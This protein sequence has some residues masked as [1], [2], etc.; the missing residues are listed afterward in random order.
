MKWVVFVMKNA[1]L[2]K[3]TGK[4]LDAFMKRHNL[5]NADI[6]DLLGGPDAPMTE[7]N[8]S[9]LRNGH[10][11]LNPSYAYRIAQEYGIDPDYLLGKSEY[12]TVSDAMKAQRSYISCATEKERQFLAAEELI[13]K[14]TINIIHKWSDL[15]RLHLGSALPDDFYCDE[16]GYIRSH[17]PRHTENQSES[18]LDKALLDIWAADRFVV[19][20][21]NKEVKVIM[22]E[23]MYYSMLQNARKLLQNSFASMID[24]ICLSDYLPGHRRA[25]VI[26][27]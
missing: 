10:T 26:I 8:V 6:G 24:A 2:N 20:V 19:L 27:T 15:E 14:E 1:E 17:A 12:E 13:I 3:K 7:Q 9:K 4:A 25:A 16:S 21:R 11:T 5:T 23:A 22:A 18:I